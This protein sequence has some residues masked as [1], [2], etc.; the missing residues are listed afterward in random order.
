MRRGFRYGDAKA[1]L[2][3]FAVSDEELDDAA[4]DE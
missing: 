1:A 3:R 2:E 4:A